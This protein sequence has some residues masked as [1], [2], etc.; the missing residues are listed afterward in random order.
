MTVKVFRVVYMEQPFNQ[1]EL[2]TYDDYF[3]H[4]GCRRTLDQDGVRCMEDDY[5]T[6]ETATDEEYSP[7]INGE[8]Y[9]NFRNKVGEVYDMLLNGEIDFVEFE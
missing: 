1:D 2:K 4:N 7:Y 5:Y 6:Y 9:D 8:Q 3:T